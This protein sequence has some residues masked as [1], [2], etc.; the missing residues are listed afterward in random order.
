MRVRR[1]QQDGCRQCG[2]PGRLR[3]A[4]RRRRPAAAATRRCGCWPRS[5]AGPAA[6][7]TP[8]SAPSRPARPPAPRA[9]SHSQHAGLV[10]LCR[11][12]LRRRRSWTAQIAGTRAYYLI[13][14]QRGTSVPKLLVL[15]RLPDGSWLSRLGGIPDRVIDAAG[16]LHDQRRARDAAAAG[17]S[18]PWPTQPAYQPATWSRSTASAGRSRAP[19]SSSSLPSSAAGSCAPAPPPASSQEVYAVLV[20]RPGRCARRSPT[21]PR[22]SRVQNQTG[23]A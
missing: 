8:C 13:R 22:P 3:R 16:H 1:H 20:D 15:Q 17:W 4:A 7:S 9:C 14:V 11:P 21:Q 23:P 12:E 2:E 18:R 6:P 19:T 10:L 5:G